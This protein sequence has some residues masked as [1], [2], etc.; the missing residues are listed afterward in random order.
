[1]AV[2][3]LKLSVVSVFE[4]RRVAVPAPHR[5]ALVVEAGCGLLTVTVVAPETL[6]PF[7]SVIVTE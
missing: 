6:A 1:M 4:A 5:V 3:Q 7:L 2:Y